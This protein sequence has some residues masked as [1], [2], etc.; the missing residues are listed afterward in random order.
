MKILKRT[1]AKKD[2]HIIEG[3]RSFLSHIKVKKRIEQLNSLADRHRKRTAIIS[4]GILTL[5]LVLGS[6]LTL[7]TAGNEYEMF[8]DMADVKP[9][10][11]GMQ[12]IQRL[13]SMQI[14][15]TTDLTNRGQRLKHEIDSLVRLPAK[16]HK[17]SVD[18]MVKYRQLEIVVEYLDNKQ[19]DKNN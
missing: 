14:E 12:R 8:E 9:A 16:S 6:W 15:Q 17:D 10:F 2:A 13:K 4:I 18:I 7:T 1:K 11:E 3:F 5:S 19:S